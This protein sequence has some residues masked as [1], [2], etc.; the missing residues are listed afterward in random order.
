MN[1]PL[2]AVTFGCFALCVLIFCSGCAT[3]PTGLPTPLPDRT[4]RMKHGYL[5]YLDGAGGGTAKKNWASGVKL[6]LLE[7]GYPGAGEMF[8][9]ETGKGLMADQNASVDYKRR[10]ASRMAK[11]VVRQS[12]AYPNAP[13]NLLGFSAGTAEVIF[14]LEDLPVGVYVHNVVLL[15]ASISDDY[16][17]TKA[18][19]HVRGKLYL[20]TSTR[21]RMLGVLMPFSG[22]ADRKFDPGAG[23]RGFVLPKHANAATRKL[24]AEKIVTLDWSK[25]LEKDGDSGRHFDNIKMPF[26]RD[27]VAPLI[28][29]GDSY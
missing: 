12:K 14:A 10:E 3:T 15:G 28:M 17:L 6:G 18:L 19:S 16:D 7:A 9:W 1:T 24:Y 23:I 5:Y 27:H 8:S 26:I 21:D 22:T 29:K 20:Y 13:I 4:E 25:T 2:R 11:E